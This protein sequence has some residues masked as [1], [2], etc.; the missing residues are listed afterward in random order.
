[1]THT[2]NGEPVLACG[3]TQRQHSEDGGTVFCLSALDCAREVQLRSSDA[4][5]SETLDRIDSYDWDGSAMIH[6]D[7]I[8]VVAWAS[9]RY[10]IALR[11]ALA[12]IDELK[13]GH[14]GQWSVPEV[15]R[16]A[17]I[18]ELVGRG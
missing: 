1:M 18:R 5:D 16:L 4:L 14:K 17:E 9:H 13:D 15:I 3:H 8:E 11:D 2:I 12:L 7:A 6:E 10:R